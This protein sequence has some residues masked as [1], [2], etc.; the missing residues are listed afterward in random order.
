[1]RGTG[2]HR[3][4]P[5][6]R[7]VDPRWMRWAESIVA[8]LAFCQTPTTP[9]SD[10]TD[11]NGRAMRWSIVSATTVSLPVVAA[12]DVDEAEVRPGSTSNLRCES[13]ATLWIGWAGTQLRRS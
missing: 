11:A 12:A 4:R 10:L 3:P 6:R 9:L 2:P 5:W 7:A 1:M 13:S 8:W